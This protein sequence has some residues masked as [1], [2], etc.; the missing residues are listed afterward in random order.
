[1]STGKAH[2]AK[3]R[4]GMVGCPELQVE[5]DFLALEFWTERDQM[6]IWKWPARE[7]ADILNWADRAS[8]YYTKMTI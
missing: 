6:R 1:M 5:K 7:F 3:K 2:S 4:R 8:N